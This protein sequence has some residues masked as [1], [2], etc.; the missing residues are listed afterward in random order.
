MDDLT[1]GGLAL[2]AAVADFIDDS[3][4][5][6]PQPAA[7]STAHEPEP[8]PGSPC[9]VA[10]DCSSVATADFEGFADLGSA[11]VLDD[12][13]SSAST[14]ASS[15]SGP[16]AAAAAPA[17]S[18]FALDC[19]P[20]W[21]LQSV[22]GRRP[23]MEDAARVLPTFF[24]VPLWMLAGDAPVDGLDRASF[25]LPAHFFGVYDG[26]G[27]LQVA[28]AIRFTTTCVALDYCSSSLI[29][30]SRCCRSP[31][32]AG[33][34][35]TRYWQRSSPRQRR[36]RPTLTWVA[37]TLTLRSTGRRSL[38]TASAVLM[39]RWEETRRPK[40]SLW[41]QTPWAQQRWLRLS[42]HRMSSLPTVATRERCSA[43]ASSLWRFPWTIK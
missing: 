17:R 41:L 1:V 23:E 28:R 5:A 26:H 29:N 21:G 35:S 3:A 22:C 30:E 7:A 14:S 39:Q 33:R 12:L 13:V 32:T 2:F 25:R 16:R 6:M 10:S 15:A 38:W 31:T 37:S 20:R 19:V 4:P 42:A 43:G 36:P 18:V 11:L 9:S 27:G 8:E 34:E 24:H 40:P